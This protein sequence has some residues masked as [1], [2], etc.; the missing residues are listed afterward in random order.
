M[1]RMT[2][3]DRQYWAGVSILSVVLHVLL[4]TYHATAPASLALKSA[5]LSGE[6][7]ICAGGQTQTARPGEDGGPGTPASGH[8]T[9]K[10]P[11]CSAAAAFA[12]LPDEPGEAV[13]I[14]DTAQ[15]FI[16]PRYG[17]HYLGLFAYSHAA[18]APPLIG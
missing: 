12:M 8:I 18:R 3:Q 2:Q 1:L 4:F 17:P 16:A 11:V 6:I 15:P 10:C 7:P 13:A 9:V 5:G 14:A